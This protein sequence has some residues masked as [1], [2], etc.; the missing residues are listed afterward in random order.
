M[1]INVTCW[2]LQL[3]PL[4]EQDPNGPIRQLGFLLA[5]VSELAIC[6]L[7]GL[8]CVSLSLFLSLY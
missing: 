7:L 1:P 3:I 5:Q 2:L 6:G 8:T 4:H